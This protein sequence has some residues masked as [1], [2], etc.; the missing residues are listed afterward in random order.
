MPFKVGDRV[1]RADTGEQAWVS[2]ELFEVSEVDENS[3]TIRTLEAPPNVPFCVVE[4][5]RIV[6]WERVAWA[7]R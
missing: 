5:D 1:R 4:R 6:F 3:F 2:S 7:A